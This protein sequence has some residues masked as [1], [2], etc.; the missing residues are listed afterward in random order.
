MN[1][2]CN[3]HC[4]IANHDPI[5]CF[6]Y[7]TCEHCDSSQEKEQ[8][9]GARSQD[10]WEAEFDL[11]WGIAPKGTLKY[12]KGQ[13]IKQFIRSHEEEVREEAEANSEARLAVKEL[14]IKKQVEERLLDEIITI[15]EFSRGQGWRGEAAFKLIEGDLDKLI[16][17]LS[18]KEHKS[19]G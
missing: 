3:C 6:V 13:S 2:N 12:E 5:K 17:K 14:R 18:K 10:G 1:R 11:L 8:P 9:F 19:E 7:Q 4:H 15:R 16:V